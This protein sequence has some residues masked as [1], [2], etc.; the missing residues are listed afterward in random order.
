MR[1]GFTYDLRDDY[2]ARGFSP[3][4]AAEFD[5]IETV[6][7]I[8]GALSFLGLSVDRIG[9]IESLTRRLAGGGT[10]DRWDFVFN[11]AEGLHGFAREAQIPAL[12]DA[13]RIPYTFSDPLALSLCLH[14]AMTKRIVRDLGLSTPKFAVFSSPDDPLPD[15]LTFPLFAKPVAEG[16][17][18]GISAASKI[19]SKAE[20]MCTIEAIL[21]RYRQPVLVEE[22]L[23]GRE[24]TVGIVGTGGKARSTGIME[25]HFGEAAESD[26]YSF[27]NKKEYEK[28]VYYTVPK[29]QLASKA[30][31]LALAV[32]K[33]L[34]LRDGGRIDV[35]EDREGNPSFIEV[36]P[37]AGLNPV[38]SDLPILSRINGMSYQRLI[39]EIVESAS[40]RIESLS[41]FLLQKSIRKETL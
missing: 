14:K 11:I 9:N 26:V 30:I 4:E 34:G 25:I 19:E 29:D 38:D 23:P 37:L 18:K 12:L 39:Y 6:E 8:E 10:S 15:D 17:G 41:H 36:N 1:V 13:Y 24:F 32:W 27:T 22:Y 2:L 31:T 33:G 21:S 40:E 35:R 28:R 20:L 3:E 7:G 5:T 16:T